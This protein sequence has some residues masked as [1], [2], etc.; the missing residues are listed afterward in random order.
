MKKLL[1]F[2]F[3]LSGSMVA[4]AQSLNDSVKA[5]FDLN[6]T[7][8]HHDYMGNEERLKADVQRIKNY[9]AQ[10]YDVRHVQVMASVSPDGTKEV[11]ENIQLRRADAM[12]QYVAQELGLTVDQIEV[13]N[14]EFDWQQFADLA[15][16]QESVQN[17]NKLQK[18]LNE[19]VALQRSGEE[20]NNLQILRKLRAIDKKAYNDIRKNVYPTLRSAKAQ[21]EMVYNPATAMAQGAVATAGNAYAN[22]SNLYKE[23]VI[24]ERVVSVKE[25]WVLEDGSRVPIVNGVPQYDQRTAGTQVAERPYTPVKE[26]VREKKPAGE[27]K[28]YYWNLKTNALYDVALVPNISLEYSFAPHWSISGEYMHAWWKTDRTNKYWRT[29]GGNVELRYWLKGEKKGTRMSGHHFGIYGGALTYDFEWG[30][31]GY[32]AHKWSKN[33]GVSYGYSFELAKRLNLDLG[34]G[35]GY[36]SGEYEEY[37]P[38]GGYYVWDATKN[39]KFFGPTR[40][41]ATLVWKLGHGNVNTKKK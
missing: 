23:R 16:Q 37:H 30:H 36:F 24:S 33:F 3:L 26:P 21:V 6:A 17:N 38:E 11:N 41:E 28:N 32:Q 34:I 39:R 4:G 8:I 19:A 14:Q 40:A 29:Y 18:V 22:D 2:L 25:Y 9:M 10:G 20:V 12:R 5:Y 13:Q 31:T 27:S 15:M 7:F 35:I 1:L